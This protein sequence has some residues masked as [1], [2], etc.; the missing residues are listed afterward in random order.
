MTH[1]EIAKEFDPET[2]FRVDELCVEFESSLSSKSPLCIESVTEELSLDEFNAA[3]PELLWL[4]WS[5]C[6]NRGQTVDIESYYARFPNHLAE[7]HKSWEIDQLRCESHG[8]DQ[9]Q[10]GNNRFQL[11]RVLAEGGLGRIWVAFDHELNRDVAIKIVTPCLSSYASIQKRFLREAK[12]TSELEHPGIPPI[13]SMGMTREHHP[14]F[15]MRLVPGVTLQQ[16]VRSL[17]ADLHD[18]HG[19]SHEHRKLDR[20]YASLEF[21]E[22]LNLFVFVC[23]VIDFAHRKSIIHRDIK[24]SNIILGKHGETTV[25]DWGLAK[26]IHSSN[27]ALS[28]EIPNEL[29]EEGNTVAG[30]ILGTPAYMSPEQAL[31]NHENVGIQSDVYSLGATFY[32]LLSGQSPSTENQRTSTSSPT[33]MVFSSRIPKALQ[34]ICRRATSVECE[35]RYQSAID[36]ANDIERWMADKSISAS[37]DSS[38]D[39]IQ[40]WTR[41]HPR[42]S[43]AILTVCVVAL[44]VSLLGSYLL[45]LHNRKL[46]ASEQKLEESE[47]TK[48]E[49]VEHAIQFIETYNPAEQLLTPAE[50]QRQTFQRMNE[51][52]MDI[53]RMPYDE[54]SQPLLK[55]LIISLIESGNAS[56]SLEII[57]NATSLSQSQDEAVAL[58]YL[59]GLALQELGKIEDAIAI[60][61]HCAETWESKADTQNMLIAKFQLA[62]CAQKMG[63][64][65]IIESFIASDYAILKEKLPVDSS[66][67]RDATYLVAHHLLNSN[68]E[69]LAEKI[70]SEIRE[71]KT[72]GLPWVSYRFLQAKMA[73]QKNETERKLAIYKEIQDVLDQSVDP[74]HP[75]LI[76]A[77]LRLMNSFWQLRDFNAASDT[78]QP[79]LKTLESGEAIPP[80]LLA[81]IYMQVA[82]LMIGKEDFEAGLPWVNKCIDLRREIFGGD[83]LETLY[84]RSTQGRLLSYLS[85]FEEAEKVLA[86]C[87]ERQTEI[88]GRDH[89]NVLKTAECLVGCLQRMGKTEN[90]IERQQEIVATNERLFGL[91]HPNTLQTLANLSWM[92]LSAKQFEPAKV[93]LE[94]HYHGWKSIAKEQPA[95]ETELY[96]AGMLLATCYGSIG[97]KD[98]ATDLFSESIEGQLRLNGANH[99]DVYTNLSFARDLIP[100]GC[101][102]KK[103]I[104]LHQKVL[105]AIDKS[106]DSNWLQ[107]CEVLDGIADVY[108]SLADFEEAITYLRQARQSMPPASD[109][110]VQIRPIELFTSNRFRIAS[111][112]LPMGRLDEAVDSLK[113]AEFAL[114]RHP[115]F[116]VA[117]QRC[118]LW[119][120]ACCVQG[121]NRDEESRLRSQLPVEFRDVP[122]VA[123]FDRTI[124]SVLA[125][126]NRNER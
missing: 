23:K 6:R 105:Q 36:F 94:R 30:E 72:K 66:E 20:L 13:Y 116:A 71:P 107:R 108:H 34:A 96:V 31:G 62:A 76:Q 45:N 83:H 58:D 125:E 123:P 120:I 51:L 73:N 93:G 80:I 112:A 85:R 57:E 79:I 59:R 99:P 10:L 64:N 97:E 106:S 53:S 69:E 60:F 15:A 43:A 92:Q 3:F 78:I 11:R 95:F 89:E 114:N 91:N 35:H 49:I 119:Q 115:E 14:Y 24:P 19:D 28:D 63:S 29:A 47:A 39:R 2:L 118:L 75:V 117:K 38:M 65:D 84:A 74:S 122:L 124:Q 8:L 44:L 17:F 7:V 48:T 82:E 100:D 26:Y 40:R 27:D 87:L 4:E 41:C 46:L 88:L 32:F 52:A 121:N 111:L 50:A 21:R 67:Y 9:P 25:I 98:Q 22:L 42:S 16:K 102:E 5:A 109:L 33:Q 81:H 113:E 86:E 110:L 54:T 56:A 126:W 37:P 70:L 104:E 1:R 12:I 101:D 103:I 55:Y 68:R 90:V 61:H 18:V 77:R